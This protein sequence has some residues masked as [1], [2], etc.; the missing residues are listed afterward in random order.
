MPDLTGAFAQVFDGLRQVVA[1][2][3][4]APLI[5]LDGNSQNLGPN[6][7]EFKITGG[8][9]MTEVRNEAGDGERVIELTITHRPGIDGAIY[10]ARRYSCAGQFYERVGMPSAP[11]E[12]PALWTVHLKPVRR[13]VEVVPPPVV[14]VVVP[15]TG[16][17]LGLV[18]GG[19]LGLVGGGSLGVVE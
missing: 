19:T 5:F 8:F 7:A 2:D 4:T 16:A 14:P 1:V 13:R 18:G 3:S 9:F 17:A 6:D 11:S 10:D 15:D 12:N